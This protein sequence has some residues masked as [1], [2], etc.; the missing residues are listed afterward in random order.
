MNIYI[1]I[2][3][4]GMYSI[5]R[6][7]LSFVFVLFFQIKSS[8]AHPVTFEDGW[9]I[10]TINRPN[11]ALWHLNYSINHRFAIGT[12][13]MRWNHHHHP[14]ELGLARA[15][16]LVK[17]WLGKG[18]QG[19]IYLL[20]GI[21]GG[22]WGPAFT[23]HTLSNQWKLA[24]MGGLQLDY[25]TPV[26]YTALMGRLLGTTQ[27]NGFNLP[28]HLIY[29]IGFAP[30]KGK[31]EQLQTWIVA[32]ASY[33]SLMEEQPSITMLMRFFYK[34]VLWEIGSD[35]LGRPWLHLMVHF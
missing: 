13:Y 4:I 9:V 14:L 30:Y 7:F 1:P 29:R 22:R 6:V 18:W 15:N 2:G 25:E 31:Y 5:N 26:F 21:G 3:G 27:M 11:M 12:D 10:S 20:G 24:W 17:R 16:L 35:T 28:H 8:H 34:T 19:N 23:D 33:A 32:Q